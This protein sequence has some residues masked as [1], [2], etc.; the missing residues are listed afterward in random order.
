M[1]RLIEA[2]REFWWVRIKSKIWRYFPSQFDRE[3]DR[4]RDQAKIIGLSRDEEVE[5]LIRLQEVR[6]EF[7]ALQ[8]RRSGG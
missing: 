6:D 5:I 7:W 2:I 4:I 8:R 3:I 1:E